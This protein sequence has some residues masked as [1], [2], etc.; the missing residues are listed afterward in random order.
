MPLRPMIWVETAVPLRLGLAG[1]G[2]GCC[3][4]A[5][6]LGLGWGTAV[7]PRR[8]CWADAAVPFGY[9][10]NVPGGHGETVATYHLGG[11]RRARTGGVGWV[12]ARLLRHGDIAGFGLGHGCCATAMKLG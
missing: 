5:I 7:A 8:Y 3:V 11:N 2:H 4:T 6:L 10:P 1:L 12:G 9:V